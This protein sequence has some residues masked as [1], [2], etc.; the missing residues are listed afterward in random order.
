MKSDISMDEVLSALLE[1]EEVSAG[2]YTYDDIIEMMGVSK[3]TASKLMKHAVKRG[4][5]TVTR[6][7][8]PSPTA[9]WQ[10]H[11]VTVF[12]PVR[13]EPDVG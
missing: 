12:H 2:G 7:L 4:L 3:S 13:Q 8:M 11:H 10:R 5:M 6:R 1:A 9:P